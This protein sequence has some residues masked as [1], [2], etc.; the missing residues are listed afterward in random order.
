M[1]RIAFNSL[2]IQSYTSALFNEIAS[3]RLRT[4]DRHRAVEGPSFMCGI[5]GLE[6]GVWGSGLGL[7]V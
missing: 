4:L 1:N 7:E 6:F 3:F 5:S 2:Y